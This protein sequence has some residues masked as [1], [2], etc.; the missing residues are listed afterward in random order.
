MEPPKAPLTSPR[1]QRVHNPPSWS[2]DMST[3]IFSTRHL[4]IFTYLKGE[5]SVNTNIVCKIPYKFI[6]DNELSNNNDD[7]N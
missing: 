1:K 7:N 5:K 4:I 6:P 3:T 2:N